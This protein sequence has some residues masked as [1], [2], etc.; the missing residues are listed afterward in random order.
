MHYGYDKQQ[1]SMNSGVK[2]SIQK[3]YLKHDH[4]RLTIFGGEAKFGDGT[5]RF[6]LI[7]IIGHALFCDWL[8]D[9]PFLGAFFRFEGVCLRGRRVFYDY[10]LGNE[11]AWIYGFGG[12]TGG[13]R[14][15]RC[16]Y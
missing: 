14:I 11:R 16:E 12:G 15:G 13:W 9:L 7:T 8:T 1:I 5:R 2:L 10:L 4:A 6:S 3:I